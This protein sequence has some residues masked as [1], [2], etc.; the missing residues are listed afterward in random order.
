LFDELDA[1]DRETS[2][3][4]VLLI[5]AFAALGL[6][7]IFADLQ[8]VMY[9]VAMGSASHLGASTFVP[10]FLI[11]TA[12]VAAIL[13]VAFWRKRWMRSRAAI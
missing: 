10:L 5:P 11:G 9:R 13:G 12:M 7:A 8:L 4:A 6:T 1:A 3:N 2:T